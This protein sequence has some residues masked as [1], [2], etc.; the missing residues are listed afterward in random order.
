MRDDRAK[1]LYDML[2]KTPDIL[3]GETRD[4]SSKE[5]MGLSINLDKNSEEL[6]KIESLGFKAIYPAELP[7]EVIARMDESRRAQYERN[8]NH[9]Y[10]VDTQGEANTLQRASHIAKHYHSLSNVA[11]LS[12]LDTQNNSMAFQS[13][14]DCKED[15][16]Q[17]IL[18]DLGYDTNLENGWL[19][20]HSDIPY[21]S[22]S[23]SKFAKIF[24]IAKDKIHSVAEKLGLNK[25]REAKV[26]QDDEMSI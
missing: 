11:G 19:T 24:E 22:V 12:A 21:P 17:N 18:N 16:L 8:K 15:N 6:K 13:A 10:F 2:S 3:A 23:K 26:K 25:N 14:S 4:T 20:V 5:T 1:M 9:A 7:D